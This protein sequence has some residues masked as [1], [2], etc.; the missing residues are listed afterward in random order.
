MVGWCEGVV[1]L[2]SPGRPTDIGL[3]L[4]VACYPLFQVRVEGGYFYFFCFFTFIPVPLSSLFISFISSISISLI[5]PAG[6][7]INSGKCILLLTATILI[8]NRS[9]MSEL[10]L[11]SPKYE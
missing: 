9:L 4:G 5:L 8:S 10:K 2:T 1:Y 7:I 11:E 6:F 3:Q